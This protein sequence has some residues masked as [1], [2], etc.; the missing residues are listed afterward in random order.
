MLKRHQNN[1]IHQITFPIRGPVNFNPIERRFYH[2]CRYFYL[3]KL[4]VLVGL[5]Y[6]CSFRFCNIQDLIRKIKEFKMQLLA[7]QVYYSTTTPGHGITKRIMIVW[8]YL[9][10]FFKIFLQVRNLFRSKVGVWCTS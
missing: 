1:L 5:C 7:K 9:N 3:G 6:C 4:R 2:K 8:C 10:R